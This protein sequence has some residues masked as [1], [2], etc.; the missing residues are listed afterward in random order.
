MMPNTVNLGENLVAD[1]GDTQVAD[2]GD[3]KVDDLEIIE[4]FQVCAAASIPASSKVR[5][6]VP[7]LL[8]LK[9]KP[10]LK[11]KATHTHIW[12]PILL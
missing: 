11:T 6:V 3:T 7:D 8:M 10:S 12:C 5:G 2:M 1:M 4:F 9:P